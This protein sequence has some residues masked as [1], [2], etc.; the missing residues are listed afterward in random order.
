MDKGAT[1]TGMAGGDPLKGLGGVLHSRSVPLKRPRIAQLDSRLQVSVKSRLR[2]L[3]PYSASDELCRLGQSY[4]KFC[5]AC[6][7]HL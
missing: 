7:P 4:L 6:S 2:N 3:N 5:K 1:R